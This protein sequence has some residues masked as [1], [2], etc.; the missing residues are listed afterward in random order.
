MSASSIAFGGSAGTRTVS[1]TNNTSTNVTFIRATMSSAKFSQANTC[2]DVAPGASCTATITYAPG[3]SGTDPGTLTLTSTAPNSPHVVTLSGGTAASSATPSLVPHFYRTI[4]RREPD[5]GG[6]AYWEG[7]LARVTGMGV[8]ASE[9]WFAMTSAFFASAE[10]V[11]LRRDDAGFVTDLYASFMNRAAD[12]SGQAYWAGLL[13]QGMPRDILVAQFMFS[14]EFAGIAAT[15]AKSARA[16]T[17][18]VIDFY[19]GLLARL[20]DS[21]G[22]THWLAQFRSAQCSGVAAVNAQADAISGAFANG[23][24]AAARGRNNA[25]YVADL[26]N[27]FLRRGGDLAG[28]SYWIQALNAGTQTRDAVRRAFLASPEFSA[29]VQQVVAAGCAG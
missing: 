5:A 19:R 28:V 29:R 1:Y 24:E 17:D 13:S 18:I 11:A 21:G 6:Q 4:L 9:V 14:P 3:N 26:Y 22:F 27:A 10:Y 23:A 15:G 7:E 8:S 16:E 25:Q 2:G 20:P 12:A